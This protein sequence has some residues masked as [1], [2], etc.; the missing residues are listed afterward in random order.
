MTES[1]LLTHRLSDIIKKVLENQMN[2]LIQ[3]E[4]IRIERQLTGHEKHEFGNA[5]KKHKFRSFKDAASL[6]MRRSGSMKILN[7]W[8]EENHESNKKKNK[9][10]LP[11][12]QQSKTKR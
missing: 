6:Q 12:K 7:Q 11:S 10:V 3:E 9:Q 1:N 5:I 8:Y 4:K 2:E